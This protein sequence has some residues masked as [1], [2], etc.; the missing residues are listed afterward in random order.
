MRE[1]AARLPSP[2]PLLRKS[3]SAVGA[4]FH[5]V[6][7]FTLSS[8]LVRIATHWMGEDATWFPLVAS[9]IIVYIACAGGVLGMLFQAATESRQS[10][11]FVHWATQLLLPITWLWLKIYLVVFGP[12]GI[13]VG[14]YLA[15]T[16]SETPSETIRRLLL[17]CA[18]FQELIALVLALYSFPLCILWRTRGEWGP[19]LRAGW[20][21]LRERSPESRPLLLLL[22][23]V[24]A[25]EAG[26]QWML[27]P[28]VY[29]S[30]PGY[31]EGLLELASS[32]LVLVVF[33]GATRIVLDRLAAG[34]RE[35]PSGAGT[36][37]PGPFA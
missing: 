1:T 18:P 6:G 19:H 34:P 30:P 8:L 31:L 36:A 27:G 16:S 13:A 5:L 7:L 14:L 25:L 22:V 3:L 10:L 32:Y 24:A 17:W 9:A 33:F 2:P 28:E 4:R 15:F 35:A 12:T 23:V 20:R 29:K 11:S 37:A 26:Q 21:V